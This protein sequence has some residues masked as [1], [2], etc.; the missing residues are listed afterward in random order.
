MDKNLRPRIRTSQLAPVAPAGV[1]P[2][3]AGPTGLLPA[4]LASGVEH[5]EL[6]F[7]PTRAAQASRSR[8]VFLEPPDEITGAARARW[9]E[10]PVAIVAIVVAAFALLVC[11]QAPSIVGSPS[12]VSNP[13]PAIVAAASV[14]PTFVV[15]VKR[16]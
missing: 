8:G 14:T 15:A 6:R 10:V 1:T 13:G 12:V 4:S 16:R 5:S 3:V 9:I 11:V 2:E 7:P